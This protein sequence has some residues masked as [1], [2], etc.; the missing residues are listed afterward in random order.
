MAGYTTGKNTQLRRGSYG[1][2]NYLAAINLIHALDP[3]LTRLHRHAEICYFNHYPMPFGNALVA[4]TNLDGLLNT[5]R[6]IYCRCQ[7]V[8]IICADHN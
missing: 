3:A 6:Q 8:H 4:S 5:I 1:L 7:N 2:I